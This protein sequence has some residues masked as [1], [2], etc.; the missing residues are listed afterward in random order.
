[1]GGG[2]VRGRF[3]ALYARMAVGGGSQ[4]LDREC[5]DRVQRHFNILLCGFRY[6]IIRSDTPDD[7]RV[8]GITGGGLRSRQYSEQK[9]A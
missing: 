3:A 4:A 5:V 2:A 1:M 6:Q 9:N 8:I 7:A